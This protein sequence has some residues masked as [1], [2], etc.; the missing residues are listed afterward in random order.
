M[1]QPNDILVRITRTPEGGFAREVAIAINDESMLPE[2]ERTAEFIG[3]CLEIF[4]RSDA[5]T[6]YPEA[7]KF[8]ENLARPNPRIKLLDS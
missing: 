7:I 1:D 2:M 4:S 5:A 3:K 6:E 8:A